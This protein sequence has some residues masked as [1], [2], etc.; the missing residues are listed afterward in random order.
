MIRVSGRFRN[1]N[2]NFNKKHPFLLPAYYHITTILST[3]LANFWQIYSKKVVRQC[4]HCFRVNQSQ[5]N[6]I[7]GD[8]P[9]SRFNVSYHFATTGV[10]CSDQFLMKSRQGKKSSF[11][12]AYVSLFIYLSTKAASA[13]GTSYR[14]EVCL[15]SVSIKTVYR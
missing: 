3:N 9:S 11:N 14:F 4:V 2:F 1:S 7:M 13:F 5:S 15:L 8:L 12:K 6:P 10:D